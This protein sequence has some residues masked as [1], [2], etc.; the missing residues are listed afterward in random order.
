MLSRPATLGSGLGFVGQKQS[1]GHMG[2]RPVVLIPVCGWGGVGGGLSL[3]L[4]ASFLALELV[5]GL[6]LG[7]DAEI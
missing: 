4:W 6:G 7:L 3:Q 1:G 5:L 2:S